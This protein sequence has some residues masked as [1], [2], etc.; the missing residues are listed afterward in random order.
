[1]L[2]RTSCLI[3]AGLLLL[4][5]A[6]FGGEPDPLVERCTEVIHYRHPALEGVKVVGVERDPS[7]SAV[8]LAFEAKTPEKTRVANHITC[9]F[10]PSSER[11]ESIRVGGRDLT[12]AEVALV[13]SE[14]LLRE[15]G[16]DADSERSWF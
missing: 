7:A 13:N 9:D 1:M 3:A 2:E 16:R 14:F 6:C 10:D 12:E 8:T 11:L 4:G 5:A 15:L